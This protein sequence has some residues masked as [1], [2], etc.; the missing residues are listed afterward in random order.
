MERIECAFCAGKVI[1]AEYAQDGI[2]TMGMMLSMLMG[3]F[4]EVKEKCD[5]GI[6]LQDGNKLCFDNSAREYAVL[7]VDIRYCPFCG[8]ELKAEETN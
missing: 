5:N 7:S 2:K 3:R 1:N 4:D 8:K 6:Q